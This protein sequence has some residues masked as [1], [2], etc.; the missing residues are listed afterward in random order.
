MY[1]LCNF[2]A[3]AWLPH[4]HGVLVSGGGTV[5]RCIHIWNSLFGQYV[6]IGTV[7]LTVVIVFP[8]SASMSNASTHDDSSEFLLYFFIIIIIII[9]Q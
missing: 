7:G 6:Y 9:D 3:L 4:H 1:H 2:I 5:D 8:P